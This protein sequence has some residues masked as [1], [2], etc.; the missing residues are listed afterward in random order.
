MPSEYSALDR[1]GRT[2]GER[3]SRANNEKESAS[4]SQQPYPP[5]QQGCGI[6]LLRLLAVMV[7][8]IFM[9][10]SATPRSIELTLK[11]AAVSDR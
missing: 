9:S 1:A 6:I 7:T 10:S 3:F 8:A 5:E 11:G 4:S 2:S